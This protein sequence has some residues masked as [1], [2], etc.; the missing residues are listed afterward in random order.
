MLVSLFTGLTAASLALA[1]PVVHQP[2]G[3]KSGE[4]GGTDESGGHKGAGSAGDWLQVT[5][6]EYS[7][8]GCP[9]GTLTGQFCPE[10]TSFN[11]TISDLKAELGKHPHPPCHLVPFITPPSPMTVHI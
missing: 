4:M 10:S 7:G 2:R 5:S 6:V 8:N 3:F 11:V 9:E 1:G